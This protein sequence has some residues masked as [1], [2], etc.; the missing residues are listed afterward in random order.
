MPVVLQW[1]Q[2]SPIFQSSMLKTSPWE[3]RRSEDPAGDEKGSPDRKHGASGGG[4]SCYRSRMRFSSIRKPCLL[5]WSME[6]NGYISI[7]GR[8][9]SRFINRLIS[10]GA[11][12]KIYDALSEQFRVDRCRRA[13]GC[14]AQ[15]PGTQLRQLTRRRWLQLYPAAQP[16]T[17]K[18]T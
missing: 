16:H 4:C 11:R 13:P 8:L 7:D 2:I 10:L 6:L 1:M 18:R 3:K 12:P 15:V 14:W 17:G 9:I 5:Y